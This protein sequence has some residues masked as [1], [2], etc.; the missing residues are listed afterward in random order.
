MANLDS[1]V[2]A[3]KS[4]NKK[5]SNTNNKKKTPVK[6]IST[7]S[8]KVIK[9][10]NEQKQEVVKNIVSSK[11]VINYKMIAIIILSFLILVLGIAKVANVLEKKDFGKSYLLDKKIIVNKIDT[12]N[13][14]EFMQKNESFI[15]ITD[16][17]GEEEYNLE[18]SL[19]E[20]ILD[21][22]LKDVF[23]V[24]IHDDKNVDLDSM[25]HLN[26]KEIKMPVILYYKNGQFVDAVVRKDE[27]MMEAADFSQLLDVYELAKKE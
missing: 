5:G 10:D 20:V 23:A 14:N 24:Y 27:N 17:L 21:N 7:S 18:K 8:K 4:T 6:K 1:K 13:V 9:E 11:E 25:F 26:G 16:S 22:N 2:S 19:K 3:K 15:Y 12:E